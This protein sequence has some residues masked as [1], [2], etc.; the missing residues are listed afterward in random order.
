M[1]HPQYN[2]QVADEWVL[3]N[4]RLLCFS[5]VSDDHPK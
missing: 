5:V 1:L 4:M 2:E 3:M